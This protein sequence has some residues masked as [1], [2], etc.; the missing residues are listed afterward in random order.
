MTKEE[1][2][3]QRYILYCFLHWSKWTE[4][5][6]KSG[7]WGGMRILADKCYNLANITT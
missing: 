7:V 5:Y 4:E 3:T 1:V 2:E 6:V